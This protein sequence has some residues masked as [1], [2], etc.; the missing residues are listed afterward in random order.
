MMRRRS[1]RPS[2]SGTPGTALWT[3]F[4]IPGGLL[5]GLFFVVPLLLVV[6]FSFGTVGLLGQPEIG[7][8]LQNYESVFQPYN[9]APL[10]RTVEFTV[11][12]TIICLLLGYPVA[13]LLARYAKRWAPIILGAVV[14]SWL[15]DYLVRIYAW[16][17]IL[18]PEGLL[19]RL[20][21]VVGLS[22]PHV[23][24]TN[25]AVITGLVY[26]YLPL[27]ILP[28]Y[29]AVGQLNPEVIEAG[30][31][32]YGSP[33]AT[34][35]HVTLPLTRD[36]VIGGV[37]LVALPMLGDFA[38]AQFLGGANSTMIGNLINDQFTAAGSQTVG[39]ALVVVLIGLLVGLLFVASRI[40]GRRVR[41]SAVVSLPLD[42]LSV[43]PA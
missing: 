25:F 12:A 36:G 35:L 38:T 10:W 11:I 2:S 28:I 31:D 29:A 18:A 14:F 27:M 17:T 41:E 13:Y 39:S 30:K 4:Q 34:F 43:D 15:V 40:R 20:L 7:F 16:Q 42:E 3:S 19:Q 22:L 24:N 32:L 1:S 9:L 26:G 21:D 5:H 33:R 37:M 23:L 6:V 8:S